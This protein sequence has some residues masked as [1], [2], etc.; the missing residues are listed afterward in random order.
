MNDP[1]FIHYT[2]TARKVILFVS[3]LLLKMYTHYL[4]RT[5]MSA[6]VRQYDPL[7]H[8][9]TMGHCVFKTFD[10]GTIPQGCRGKECALQSIEN[11]ILLFERLSSKILS[12]I[13]GKSTIKCCLF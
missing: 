12:Q 8:Y 7:I 6:L 10:S 9:S 1:F 2:K 4:V 11:V 3:V 13:C 5:L